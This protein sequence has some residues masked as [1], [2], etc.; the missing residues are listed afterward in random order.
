[1]AGNVL[2]TKNEVPFFK[3][4]LISGFFIIIGLFLCFKFLELGFATIVVVPLIVNLS[5]QAWKWPL[6]L[7]KDLK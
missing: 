5:Y 1:M 6:E 2:L 4:S 7:R 3:A